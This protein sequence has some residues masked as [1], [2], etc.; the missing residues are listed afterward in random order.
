MGRTFARNCYFILL[1]FVGYLFI[2]WMLIRIC[3]IS[4]PDSVFTCKFYEKT[5]YYC[6]G[7]GGTRA[8]RLCLQ[9][10]FL[11]SLKYHPAVLAFELYLFPFFISHTAALLLKKE[12]WEMQIRRWH[13]ILLSFIFVMP[14]IVKNIV[15]LIWHIH[16]M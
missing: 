4:I 10:H 5:G 13:V 8:L 16:L 1:A 11:K 12:S 6:P 14:C 9:G 3:S 15:Y 7:C 2:S